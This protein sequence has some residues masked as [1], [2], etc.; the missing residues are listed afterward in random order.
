[1]VCLACWGGWGEEEQLHFRTSS[2]KDGISLHGLRRTLF[3]APCFFQTNTRNLGITAKHLGSLPLPVL[4]ELKGGPAP[5]LDLCDCRNGFP[6]KHLDQSHPVPAQLQ[7]LQ[8]HLGFLGVQVE[9][10]GCQGL[11]GWCCISKDLDLGIRTGTS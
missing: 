11:P 10:R 9:L 5:S 2:S 4:G 6:Y 7:L 3:W 1:M 8:P